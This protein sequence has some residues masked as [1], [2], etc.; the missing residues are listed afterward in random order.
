[1]QSIDIAGLSRKLTTALAALASRACLVAA[2]GFGSMFGGE[3]A[4]DS[5]VDIAL[6]FDEDALDDR[7]RFDMAARIHGELQRV[8]P[9]EVDLVVLN[10]APPLLAD[11]I[12]RGGHVL[13]GEADPRRVAFEHR[14]LIEYLDFLPVLERYDRA[15][16]ARA[17]EGRLGA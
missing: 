6:L 3:P 1:V 13:F 12:V 8:S 11:R 10:G 17:R 5:D 15:L 2:Y 9:R 4:A 14:S 16:L 7:Q